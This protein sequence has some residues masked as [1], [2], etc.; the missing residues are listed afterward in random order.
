MSD[1]RFRFVATLLLA[2]V[3][4]CTRSRSEPPDAGQKGTHSGA[5]ELLRAWPEPMSR[6]SV[7]LADL[8]R[9]LAYKIALRIV[10][11][12]IGSGVH[13]LHADAMV[14]NISARTVRLE[15]GA[16]AVDL[17]AYRDSTQTAPVVWDSRQRATWPIGSEYGCYAFLM[18]VRLAPGESYRGSGMS[19]LRAE[20]PVAEIYA[21][22]L[23]LGVYFFDAQLNLNRDTFRLRAGRAP[24]PQSR[25]YLGPEYPLDGFRYRIASEQQ[26]SR[27]QTFNLRVEVSNSGLRPDLTRYVAREC[28]VVLHAYQSAEAQR[29]APPRPVWA[30]PR[31]CLRP[32]PQPIQLR[33]GEMRTL[34]RSFTAH[35]VLGDSLRPGRYYFTAIVP[36][37]DARRGGLSRRVWLDAGAFDLSGMSAP[38]AERRQPTNGR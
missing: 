6:E 16:C 17:F 4:G 1:C 23:P 38:S 7:P 2:V 32:T 22:S 8:R 30:S 27:P 34:A 37:V 20:I 9:D 15:H 5:G 18:T 11:D 14:T 28:P 13:V 36:L 33:T 29:T 31:Q 3:L 26:A 25:F 24:L 21:D 19:Q 10:E 35:E 12:S